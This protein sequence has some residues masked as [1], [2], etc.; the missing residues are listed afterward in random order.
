M[1]DQ[2]DFLMIF[3]TAALEIQ[4]GRGRSDLLFHLIS[5]KAYYCLL[6]KRKLSF[7]KLNCRNSIVIL[8]TYHRVVVTVHT[9]YIHTYSQFECR[10]L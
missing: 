10:H 4:N 2:F 1:F 3:K 6:Q 7:S 9:K 8:N 5:V